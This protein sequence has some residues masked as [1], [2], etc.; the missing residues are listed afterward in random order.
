MSTI[1]RRALAALAVAAV[2]LAGLPAAGQAR[3]TAL[4][5]NDTATWQTNNTVRKL[6][7]ANGMI[8]AGGE[9]TSVR[10]PGAAP[11]TGEVSRNYLAAFDAAT[12][13][14]IRAFNPA[15]NGRVWSLAASPDGSRV[16]VGGDFTSM[17][18][19]TRQRL[20]AI[21]TATLSVVPN[22]RPNV[23]YRVSA[24]SATNDTV[25]FGGSFGRVNNND[26]LRAAA[27]RA[28][29]SNLLPWNPAP[30]GDVMTMLVSPDQSRVYVGGKFSNIGGVSQWALSGVD[31]SSGLSLPLPAAS[32]IP[33]LTSN[34][35]SMPKDMV[36]DGT[37][38][39]VANSGDGGGCFDGT[40]AFTA[41]SGALTWKN[42]CLGATEALGLVG[43]WLYK[44]S[45]AH[46][47]ASEGQFAT[48]SRQLLAQ[49][50]R[51]GEVQ[52]WYP[53]TNV[54]GTTKVGPFAMAT[55]GRRLWVGGD[56][57]TVNNRGQQGL[58]IF[59]PDP[60][61]SPTRPLTPS[62]GSVRPGA[63]KVVFQSTLD[64]D[65]EYLTYRLY[66]AGTTEPI[67]TEVIRSRFWSKP[68]VT[69]MDTGLQ[70]D[71]QVAY[72][73]EASDGATTVAS[74]WTPYVTVRSTEPVYREAVELDGA[75][76]YWRMD[77][78]SGTTASDASGAG[79]NGTYEGGVSLGRSGVL[80]DS[81]AAEFGQ[82]SKVTSK[83]ILTNPQT[84]SVEGWIRTE[85]TGGGRI[86][87]F[88]NEST[89]NS[90]N[91]DRHL[92]MRNDGHVSFG[93]YDGR[94]NI[95]SSQSALNDGTWHH[96]VGTYSPGSMELFVDGVSQGTVGVAAAQ[97][98]SGYWRVG[99]DSLGGWPGQ[100]SNAGF[101]GLVDEVAVYSTAL[102]ADDVRWHYGLASGHKPPVAS[103]VS[104]CTALSCTFDAGSS[105]DSDGT[106][107][108][109]SWEFGDGATAE[110]AAVTHTYASA[111]TKTVQL[112]VTDSSGLTARHS[113]QVEVSVP[114]TEPIADFEAAC[115]V[116]TCQV[117][118]RGSADPDGTITE[119][120]WDFGDGATATGPTASHTYAEPGGYQISLTVTD[121]R[122]AQTVRV[123][124]VQ[125]ESAVDPLPVVF[126]GDEFGRTVA[127]GLGS[128]DTGGAW[129][130]AGSAARYSVAGGTGKLIMSAPGNA[131]AA[132][133]SSATARESDV[134]VS[135]SLDKA[136]TG[137]GVYVSL[138][139]RGT[140]AGDYRA[141]VRYTSSARVYLAIVRTD[142]AGAET[143]LTPETL[144]P[145]LTGAPGE[146]INV[147]FQTAGTTDTRLSAKAWL[148]AEE[149]AEW[150]V[151]AADSTATLQQAGW[152]GIRAHLSGSATNAPVELRM[153]AFKATSPR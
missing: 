120:A 16:Y 140:A 128:A 108:S 47:C 91:Y 59:G 52:G 82:N 41:A 27:V 58:G 46:D 93:V 117:D 34:C 63:V 115:S 56:F 139:G 133:L 107:E 76:P 61:T 150:T 104:S 96:V 144:V 53:N 5:A 88:G 141:K 68:A 28:S 145:G 7:Y 22:F 151:S 75:R 72:R 14:L 99:A 31:T 40:F 110:G 130:V 10:P 80:P 33:P 35:L 69:V 20:A 21:D 65:D 136:A 42:T 137:G 23:S 86:L 62:A 127:R 37:T 119:W 97:N 1:I 71:S 94:T 19:L 13:D 25:Y 49:D 87:G 15:P 18:S 109:W 45:H 81:K 4:A 32:A 48:G 64:N 100:P 84:F 54:G 6:V 118:G 129:T 131:P 55:D 132:T 51:T 101:Q 12:G 142:A 3:Q 11:G 153:S 9:F 90:G 77:E 103:F 121:D 113:A 114:N 134:S 73:V 67:H 66:R 135:L 2:L 147:R 17:G 95:V 105:T 123:Q 116:L 125:V 29:D 38:V 112:T 138:T 26:R 146:K 122:G 43:G 78:V 106:V 79:I 50:V 89:N 57:T 98:Y 83:N 92:Y 44:G 70:P 39:Y 74:Y 152:V 8:F 36:T 85:T 143:Y 60:Q 148:G 149:P 102:S 30:D 124:S 126:A 111:G 24:I